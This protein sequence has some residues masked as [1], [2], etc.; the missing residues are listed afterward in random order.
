MCLLITLSESPTENQ[1]CIW[2]LIV[3]RKSDNTIYMCEKTVEKRKKN[4]W[5]NGN[6]LLSRSLEKKILRY[7]TNKTFSAKYKHTTLHFTE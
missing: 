2:I 5:A 3:I 6:K 4:I 1:E 7:A